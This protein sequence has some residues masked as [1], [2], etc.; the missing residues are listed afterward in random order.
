MIS[1]WRLSRMIVLYMASFSSVFFLMSPTAYAAHATKRETAALEVANPITDATVNL[2]CRL[3]A[4]KQLL[5][6]S[7]SGVFISDRGVILT[8]AHVAQYFLLAGEKGRVT[9]WCSVRTGSRAKE[10]YTAS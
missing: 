2:Y 5:S 1:M 8:N 4:G 9:G 6:A 10:A 7:G 3:K